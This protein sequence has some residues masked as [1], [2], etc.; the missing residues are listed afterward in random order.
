M[1]F[2]SEIPFKTIE[3]NLL[4]LFDDILLK[5]NS[6]SGSM[7]VFN[8]NKKVIFKSLKNIN[9][10][11]ESLD[12]GIIDKWALKNKNLIHL[13][14][15][16]KISGLKDHLKRGIKDAIIFPIYLNGELLSIINL[17]KKDSFYETKEIEILK[18]HKKLLMST[19]SNIFY[20][21]KIASQK[22]FFENQTKLISLILNIF[23]KTKTQERFIEHLI[24][25]LRKEFHI[26]IYI[27]RTKEKGKYSIKV[28]DEYYNIEIK[29]TDELNVLDFFEE[30]RQVDITEYINIL[31]F[32]EKLLRLKKLEEIDKKIEKILKESREDLMLRF[33]SWKVFQEINS[34]LSSIYLSLYTIDDNCKNELS[35]IIP[36]LDRI[37]NSITAYKKE[38]IKTEISK[39][40][41]SKFMK[42]IIDKLR[43]LNFK[44]EKNVKEDIELYI[45]KK[46]FENTLISFIVEIFKILHFQK[47]T[48][49]IIIKIYK[50]DER[51]GVIEI[52]LK[53]IIIQEK[54]IDINIIK[55]TLDNFHMK[56][57]IENTKNTIFKIFIPI[58]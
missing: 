38:F 41:L 43:I 12:I 14:D 57:K 3:E 19:I 18:N 4:T 31:M 2:Y 50:K 5:T 23:E 48:E 6:Y 11:I 28:N 54:D 53:N 8:H 44:M 30:K 29:Y 42:E 55:Q 47:Y 33:T 7:F 45:D 16:K 49:E 51:C 35:E 34:A 21:K 36:S 15:I 1:E 56:L 58:K 26:D 24:E 25:N 20:I 27:K 52:F 40:S 22:T 10:H 13:S 39:I 37:K 32:V 46:I 9:I 17:N